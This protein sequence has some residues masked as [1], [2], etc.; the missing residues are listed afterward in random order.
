MKSMKSLFALLGMSLVLFSFSNCGSSNIETSSMQTEQN[1]PFK[2]VNSY[3][4]DWVAGIQGGGSGTNIHLRFETA[5]P[6]V[7]FLNAYFKNNSAPLERKM[8]SAIAYV[9]NIKRGKTRPDVI[10]DSNPIKEAQNTPPKKLPLEI[11]SEDVAITY[12]YKENTFVYV[13]KNIERKEMLAYPQ[14]NPKGDN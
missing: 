8:T 12:R 10:M 13:I 4:Q 2:L 1:P 11:S 3:Y 9:A 6:E 7:T 5:D 14:G